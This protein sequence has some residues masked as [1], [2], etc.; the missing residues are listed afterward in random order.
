MQNYRRKQSGFTLIEVMIVVA[1]IG[2][3]ASIAYPSYRES[4]AKGKRA[5]AK[6]VLTESQQWMERFYSENYRYDQNFAVVSVETTLFPAQFSV[7]PKPGD[8]NAAYTITVTPTSRSYT[9]TA[10]P[11]SADRCGTYNIT[12]TGRKSVTSYTGFA[13]A[14]EAAR[15]CWR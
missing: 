4:I 14:L 2:I 5:S 11:I 10:T 1:I 9:V 8:G 7:A 6:S 3:L 15:E 12:H 13:N